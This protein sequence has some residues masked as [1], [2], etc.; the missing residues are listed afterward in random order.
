[1]SSEIDSF[2]QRFKW[3]VVIICVAVAIVVLL[4]MFT[5][6]FQSTKSNLVGQLVLVLGVLVAFSALLAMLSRLF[7]ILD[8]LRD[9]S[10]KLEAVSPEL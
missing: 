1:M 5:D 4:T 6:I 3:H 2:L 8:V 7:K 9:N 10:S